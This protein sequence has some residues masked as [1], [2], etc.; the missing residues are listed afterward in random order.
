MIEMFVRP[1]TTVRFWLYEVVLATMGIGLLALPTNMQELV[2]EAYRTK[3]EPRVIELLRD[4]LSAGSTAAT[5]PSPS[6]TQPAM[7]P[8]TATGPSRSAADQ[9]ATQIRGFFC[10]R[11]RERSLGDIVRSRDPAL[12]LTTFGQRV[13]GSLVI[14]YL[15]CFL[16]PPPMTR[17]EAQEQGTQLAQPL[18]RNSKANQSG[19]Q[20]GA[21]IILRARQLRVAVLY[22]I[23]GGA[24]TLAFPPA[25]GL[26][27]TPAHLL[28]LL[29]V[30]AGIGA[31]A[32]SLFS[33][34]PVSA[35]EL[36]WR[37]SFGGIFFGSLIALS[38][39]MPYQIMAPPGATSLAKEQIVRIVLLRLFGHPLLAFVSGWTAI[40]IMRRDASR[41]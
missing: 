30:A 20:S 23:L 41:P 28:A 29:I 33:S 4:R 38:I 6:A 5:Q 14:T 7:P 32:P 12:M 40:S 11:V 18:V 19:V 31:W 13:A 27:P 17:R 22:A 39:S 35:R 24:A 10:P 16:I 9:I 26:G 15:I 37:A 8:N 2:C 25:F 1:V 3:V 34:W 21:D 36:A